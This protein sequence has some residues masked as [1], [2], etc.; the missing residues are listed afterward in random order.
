VFEK[1]RQDANMLWVRLLSL[2]G[3]GMATIGN[4]ISPNGVQ[5]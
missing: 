5:Y 4:Q 1:A 2:T 3:N